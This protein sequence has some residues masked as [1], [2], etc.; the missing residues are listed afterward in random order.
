MAEIKVY[1]KAQNRVALGIVHAYMQMNPSSTLEDLRK[2]F[3][4]SINP[5]SGVQENFIKAEE[6]G[7]I[8]DWN[9]YFKGEDEVVTTGDGIKVAVVSMWT[10]PSFE[11]IV[12]QAN[13]YGIAVTK[14]EIAEKSSGGAGFR[15]EQLIEKESPKE[16]EKEVHLVVDNIKYCITSDKKVYIEGGVN[17]EGD[18]VIPDYIEYEGESYAVTHFG[19]EV[20]WSEDGVLDEGDEDFEDLDEDCEC[21]D[22]DEESEDDG[23]FYENDKIRSIVLPNTL[24]YLGTESILSCPNLK[25]VTIGKGAI[26]ID[27]S[28]ISGCEKLS[29]VI[30][31][32]KKS[33]V[34][35]LCKE[36][37]AFQRNAKNFKIT[38]KEEAK[39]K[40]HLNAESF[41]DVL[42]T[43]VD[44]ENV[45]KK[46]D[47]IMKA[48]PK[49]VEDLV[50]FVIYLESI[51]ALK[52]KKL[53]KRVRTL[54]KY[55]RA[56]MS[57]E[58]RIIV[59]KVINAY[60]RKILLKKAYSWLLTLIVAGL[61]VWWYIARV[62]Y[63]WGFFKV[64]WFILPI[65]V[66]AIIW[67][68]KV[69]DDDDYDPF[70]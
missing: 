28:A 39:L 58:Q 10:K 27:V 34:N 54:T 21:E 41:I 12:A 26:E 68:V 38:Y 62:Q 25:K 48:H 42:R 45:F 33:D 49:K 6:K 40:D 3:P 53:L 69:G 47:V 51:D 9:G 4:N 56:N 57:I 64:V 23:G 66:F 22:L 13:L 15:L 61:F 2:A 16:E 36:S 46:M 50:A 55:Q 32:A 63:W 18:I 29:E 24:T 37:L 1:A 70:L 44:Q 7:T 35:W 31:L 52:N 14:L 60:S 65:V 67:L 30:I 5:D 43:K 59:E 8:G 19:C 11:R 17:L 20:D